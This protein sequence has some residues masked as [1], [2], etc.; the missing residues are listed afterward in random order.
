MRNNGS[1]R[2]CDWT[3]SAEMFD[4]QPTRVK[5]FMRQTPIL[6][7]HYKHSLIRAW[8]ASELKDRLYPDFLEAEDDDYDSDWSGE[9]ASSSLY[10]TP[11][12]VW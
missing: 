11:P 10:I 5:N 4:G 12:P 9:P 6:D 7:H 2:D 3:L 1:S 8:G